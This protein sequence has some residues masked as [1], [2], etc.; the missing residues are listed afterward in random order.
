MSSAMKRSARGRRTKYV[1]GRCPAFDEGGTQG[2]CLGSELPDVLC[3]SRRP[4][5]KDS[6]LRKGADF[7][8]EENVLGKAGPR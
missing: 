8:L 2:V 4:E 7:L 5:A 1:P 3:L 6:E